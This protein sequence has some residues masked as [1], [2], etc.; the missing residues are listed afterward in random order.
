[1][2]TDYST[3][4]L[5]AYLDEAAPAGRMSEIESA[6]RDDAELRERLATLV[7][8]RD[9]GLHS[10]GEVWRR[11]RLTCPTREQLGSYLL[12]VLPDGPD[13]GLAGYLRFHVEVVECRW[14]LANLEDLREKHAGAAEAADDV[15]TRRG[16]YFQS[17]V[18]RLSGA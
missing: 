8:A 10:L 11:R 6:L 2:P 9:A 12:G 13:G 1:M 17:S 3:A 5:I 15:E 7:S 14:C 16:R 4:E 18:G